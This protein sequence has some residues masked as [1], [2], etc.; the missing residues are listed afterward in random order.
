M[1]LRELIRDRAGSF[2]RRSAGVKGKAKKAD[3]SSLALTI[4]VSFTPLAATQALKLQTL[5]PK[6]SGTNIPAS[7]YE[8]SVLPTKH[9]LFF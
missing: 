1:Y 5:S 6:D 2:A 7:I 3:T 9:M 8:S 4:L